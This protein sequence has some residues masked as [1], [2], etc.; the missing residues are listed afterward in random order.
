MVNMR[1]TGNI[2][3]CTMIE[4]AMTTTIAVIDSGM[5]KVIMTYAVM[6]I[7]GEIPSAMQPGQWT[8]EIVSGGEERVLPVKQNVT[9]VCIAIGQIVAIEV[10]SR[11]NAQ[12][13]VEIDFIA[14]TI[15]L[16]GQVQLVCHLIGEEAGLFACFIVTHGRE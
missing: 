4:A 5:T 3:A 7:D 9:N 14:I 11:L 1:A 16:I 15:L 10:V 8:E 13:I 12:Q 6:A 2:I